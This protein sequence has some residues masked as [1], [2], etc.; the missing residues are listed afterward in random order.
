[1]DPSYRRLSYIRYADDHLLGFAGPK[2]EAEQIKTELA[3][4]LRLIANMLKAGYLEDWQYRET[5]SGCPQGGVFT[6]PTQRAISA[7]R[8]RWVTGGWSVAGEG[9]GAGGAA[10]V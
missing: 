2:A 4:F 10:G 6:P 3:R 5:L 1:M 7:S 8:S 9:R